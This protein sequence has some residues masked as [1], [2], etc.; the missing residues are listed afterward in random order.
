MWSE[1]IPKPLK[2]NIP[3]FGNRMLTP[4]SHV[5]CVRIILHDDFHTLKDLPP[6]KGLL[7]RGQRSHINPWV[8]NFAIANR[9]IGRQG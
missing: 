8:T 9:E 1:S 3:E 2:K 4:H 7:Y 5:P 6:P